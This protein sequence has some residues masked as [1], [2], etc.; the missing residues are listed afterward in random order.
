MTSQ[1]QDIF[2]EP[3]FHYISFF[4]NS[5]DPSLSIRLDAR[6]ARNLLIS[7]ATAPSD[8]V[9][10]AEQN[11]QKRWGE[12]GKMGYVGVVFE[13]QTTLVLFLLGQSEELPRPAH[14]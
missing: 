8:A 13:T 12:C 10:E 4:L 1:E 3:P 5:G 11:K 6:R 7:T 9:D 14:V 2:A